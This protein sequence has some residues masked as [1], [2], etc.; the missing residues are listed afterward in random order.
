MGMADDLI[1]IVTMIWDA[2]EASYKFSKIYDET[3]VHKL[4]WGAKRNITKHHVKFICYV[5]RKRD[6]E[7]W[8]EQ[9]LIDN[10]PPSYRDFTQPYE[11]DEPMILMGLDTVIVGNLDNLVAH[12]LKAKKI[13]LPKAVF[14]ANTVCNGVAL[15][16]AGC[17]WVYDQW[18][19]EN[20]MAVMRKHYAEGKIDTFDDLFPRQVV[21]Y[22]KHIKPNGDKLFPETRIVFLHGTHGKPHELTHLDWIQEHWR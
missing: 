5:D 16:P 12:C 13:V 10:D 1:N 20:D 22:W 11:L 4:Y 3:W 8:I 9:R 18:D 7:P 19:G 17:K 15:V 6:L 2:N 14:R 21:S